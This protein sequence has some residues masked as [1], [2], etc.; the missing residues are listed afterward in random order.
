M[1]ARAKKYY[2][3]GKVNGVKHR[4]AGR[5][6]PKVAEFLCSDG[7]THNDAHGGGSVRADK[8]GASKEFVRAAFTQLLFDCEMLI[9]ILDSPDSF[10]TIAEIAYACGSNMAAMVI[11]Y[12]KPDREYTQKML[13]AYWFVTNFAL[14]MPILVADDDEALQVVNNLVRIESPI[15][16]RFYWAMY[17]MENLHFYD[18]EAQAPIN[19]GAFTYRVD[20]LYRGEGRAIAIELDGHDSH[21]SRE[22][23]THDARKDRFLKQ[24]GID[25]VRFTGSEITAD[26]ARCVNELSNLIRRK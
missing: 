4:I 18:L 13:D 17:V 20:F 5:V 7:A 24:Q 16:W 8:F 10:G 22:Q 19:A 25:V 14:A 9:A 21:K 3:A 12:L 1:A 23:R 2:L 15:E 26:A 11:I 6:D